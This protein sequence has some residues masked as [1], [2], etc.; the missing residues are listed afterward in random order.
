[1]R[2]EPAQQIV[3]LLL[4]AKEEMIFVGLERAKTRKRIKHAGRLHCRE[5]AVRLLSDT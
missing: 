2:A 3:G 5:M 1:M 4:T